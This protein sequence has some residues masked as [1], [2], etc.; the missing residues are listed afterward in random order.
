M[1]TNEYTKFSTLRIDANCTSTIHIHETTDVPTIRLTNKNLQKIK[2]SDSNTSGELSI[3]VIAE[4]EN[5]HVPL[6][7]VSSAIQQAIS[8]DSIRDFIPN[9]ISGLKQTHTSKSISNDIEV[10][11]DVFIPKSF[12]SV[13]ITATNLDLDVHHSSIINIDITSSNLDFKSTQPLITELLKIA[14]PNSN[15]DFI[16]ANGLA[17]AEIDG[18]NCDLAIRRAPDFDGKIKIKGSNTD[19]SGNCDGDATKGLITCR[20][21]NANVSILSK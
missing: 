8:K 11:F 17:F 12:L 3:K 7:D 15:I 14:A 4:S 18:N 1:S 6:G 5:T 10:I 19:V 16:A 9:F 20:M 13:H 21:S 2:I